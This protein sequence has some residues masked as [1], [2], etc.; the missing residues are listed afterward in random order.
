MSIKGWLHEDYILAIRVDDDPQFHPFA[1]SCHFISSSAG[2][3][4]SNMC[5]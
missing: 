5:C 4:S 2:Y 3:V 1:P